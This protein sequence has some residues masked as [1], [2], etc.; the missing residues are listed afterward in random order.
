MFFLNVIPFVGGI[1]VFV[2]TL[3]PSQPGANQYGEMR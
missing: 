2:F 1:I 3:L